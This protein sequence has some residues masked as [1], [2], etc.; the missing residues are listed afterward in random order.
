MPAAIR[1]TFFVSL[2]P[3]YSTDKRRNAAPNAHTALSNRTRNTNSSRSASSANAPHFYRTCAS[4]TR[5]AGV[6]YL[7]VFLDRRRLFLFSARSAGGKERERKKHSRSARALVSMSIASV[8]IIQRQKRRQRERKSLTTKEYSISF[9]ASFLR[10]NIGTL[11]DETRTVHQKKRKKRRKNREESS[12]TR[13]HHVLV[14]VVVVVTV[15]VVVPFL[16]SYRP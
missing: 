9:D 1:P 12:R 16:L 3:I 10:S 5:G 6:R 2:R 15:S 13:D 4:R 14:S 7:G 8:I 11:F